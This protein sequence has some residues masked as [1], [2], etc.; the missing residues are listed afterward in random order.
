[1]PEESSKRL[2]PRMSWRVRLLRL[3]VLVAVVVGIAMG[4]L[5]NFQRRLVFPGAYVE[6]GAMPPRPGGVEVWTLDTDAGSVE[7]WLMRGRGV[8]AERP[9]PAVMYF[10]GNGELID[11]WPG[12]MRWFVERGIS[13]LLPEYRG[14][15]RSAG[16][17]NGAEIAADMRRWRER[18]GSTEGVDGSRI[19]YFGRS[20][21]GGIAAELT[22]THPPAALVLSSA[23]TSVTDVVTETTFI[24]GFL[25][26]DRFPVLPVLRTY[27]GPVLLLHGEEDPIIPVEHARR[28][29]AAAA[30][31][32]LVTYPGIG[33]NDTPL[34]ARLW[35]DLG[36]FFERAGVSPAAA[37]R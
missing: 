8:S 34:G 10:H 12:E 3:G 21:G 20:L 6:H 29:A 32:T 24:P 30:G 17:P 5:W 15:G 28:N 16:T 27:P 7:A 1:M 37:G 2:K 4:L 14:Y 31:A 25:V 19:V 23:F 9:G 35:E 26:R 33:H 36:P 22:R 11:I 18:L 13:V